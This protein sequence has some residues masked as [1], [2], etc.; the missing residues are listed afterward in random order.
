MG[1]TV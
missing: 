1:T